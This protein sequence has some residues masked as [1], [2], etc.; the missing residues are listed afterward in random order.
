MLKKLG[1]MVIFGAAL[2]FNCYA[3]DFF[4][5]VEPQQVPL[6]ETVKL[7]LSYNGDDAGRL[8]PD[9]SGLRNDFTIYATSNSMQSNYTNGVFQQKRIWKL[10][11]MPKREGVLTIPAISAGNYQTSPVEV[12]V[13]P[14]GSAVVQPQKNATSAA[15]GT[16]NPQAAANAQ[17][18]DFWAEL[19]VESKTPYVEQELNGTIYIYDRKGIQFRSE[20]YFDDTDDWDIKRVGNAEISEK[21]GQKVIRFNYAFFPKK[22]GSLTIPVARMEGVYLSYE[23]TPISSSIGGLFRMFDAN[24]DMSGLLGVQK[25]VVLQTKPMTINVKPIPENYGKDWWLPA[26]A[27]KLSAK[28]I[29]ER[30]VFKVGEAVT[31]EISLIASGV[32][33]NQLPELEFKETSAWKQ[34][35]EKPRFTTATHGNEFISEAVTRVVYIPQRGSEQI[36]PE[37]RLKWYNLK[38]DK[39]E[40]AVIPAEKMYVAG[41]VSDVAQPAAIPATEAQKTPAAVVDK[42]APKIAEKVANTATDKWLLLAIIIGAFL[43]G[44]LFN[45]LF[46][47]NKNANA[48]EVSASDNLHL[49]EN[50][51][52]NKD[53]RA[54]RDNLIVW[55]QKRYND[56]FINNL[57]VLADK[58]NVQEFREQM[59][60]L[61]GILYAGHTD[62][63][64][65]KTILQ[66]LKSKR[67]NETEKKRAPLP[68]LY[69]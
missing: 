41:P 63:L 67:V 46:L 62:T 53:Y 31:R 52:K 32:S 33:E 27:L 68:E 24:F 55:G 56:E 3:G 26:T 13:L 1:F 18:S 48:K 12:E 19:A 5:N 44:I 30:P 6:G 39:M 22:S 36:I 65:D 21:N 59:A 40:M 15:A 66:C 10:T 37:I 35:P 57:N 38:D 20:P 9:F 23:E 58:V 50:N 25:P 45:Y 43:A 64:D 49:I 11:L 47:R 4:A 42:S 16:N 28:W 29:D 17:S 51:L 14:S 61:N 8:Q 54:L 69:K 7:E 34:Y 60:V 2:A